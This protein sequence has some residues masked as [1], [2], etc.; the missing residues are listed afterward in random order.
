MGQNAIQCNCRVIKLTMAINTIE[1][2]LGPSMSLTYSK[3]YN[4]I[5]VMRDGKELRT[6]IVPKGY[7][8][9]SFMDDCLRYKRIMNY[10]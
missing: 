2:E 3:Q 8:L 10:L 5:Q 1:A 4:A 7:T 9:N 6:E